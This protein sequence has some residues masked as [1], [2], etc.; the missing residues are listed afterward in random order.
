MA[1]TQHCGATDIFQLDG[2]VY[3][4][5]STTI[6]LCLSVFEWT[7]FRKKKGGVKVHVIYNPETQ[8]LMLFNITS[9][10][11]YDTKAMDVI[12]YEENAFYIFD[13]AI[14]TSSGFTTSKASMHTCRPWKKCND[15]CPVS[16][17]YKFLP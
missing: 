11:L 1:E 4:F 9:A 5:D 6:D 3:A 8:T 12:P 10:K 14:M 2:K 16:W 15:F 13:W 7:L 17:K